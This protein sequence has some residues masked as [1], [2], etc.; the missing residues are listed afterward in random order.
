MWVV[1]RVWRGAGGQLVI[2][3]TTGLLRV[4]ATLFNYPT[5][6]ENLQHLEKREVSE[7][8]VRMLSGW[9]VA[10]RHSIRNSARA[11]ALV[12]NS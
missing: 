1:M 5:Q 8:A 4:G 3:G 12:S 9:V 6:T 11:H 10:T 2:G 7:V